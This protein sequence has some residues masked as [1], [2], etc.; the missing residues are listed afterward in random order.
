VRL[1]NQEGL[2][3]IHAIIDARQGH[4]AITDLSGQG[5]LVNG[6]HVHEALYQEGDVAQVGPCLLRLF[7]GLEGRSVAY[8][9]P[10]VVLLDTPTRVQ[11]TP[12]DHRL[13]DPFGGIIQLPQGNSILGRGAAAQ[14]RLDYDGRISHQHALL[15]VSPGTAT[16]SSLDPA[17][18]TS[19]NGH[20][21]SNPVEL[22]N[23][24][25]IL[26]GATSL[27]YRS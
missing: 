12:R 22:Q 11:E 5:I 6:Y 21:V 8:E 17:N 24:D 16:L 15:Q 7:L 19:V 18:L 3:P 26:V 27:Q 9:Q 25:R 1:P 13:I 4:W 10:E 23:G 2:Q 14:I 20:H